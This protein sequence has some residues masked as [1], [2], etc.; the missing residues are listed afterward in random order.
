MKNLSKYSLII[1]TIV[2]LGFIFMLYTFSNIIH[3]AINSDVVNS[4][5]NLPKDI[6]EGDPLKYINDDYTMNEKFSSNLP[7]IIIEL[8]SELPYYKE[9]DHVN[10]GVIYNDIEPWTT[11]HISIISNEK[12]INNIND[13]AKWQSS[14]NVKRRGQTTYFYE[15]PQ[16]TI[17]L[18]SDEAPQIDKEMNLF[19]MG[20]DNTWAII[21]SVVDKSLIRNYLAYSIASEIDENTL[22][23]KFCEV[24]VKDGESYTYQGV[25]LFSEKVSR[26]K[27]RVNIENYNGVDK[28]SSYI[29]RRDRYTP[30]DVIIDNY[31]RTDLG[32]DTYLGIKYPSED[33]LNEVVLDYITEDFNKIEKTLYSEDLTTKKAYPEYIDI[34]SFV[35]YF[36]I[37][38][39]FGNYDAGLH[40]TYMYKNYDNSLKI[41]PVWDFDQAMNNYYLVEQKTEYTAMQKKAFYE[42]LIKDERF[43][44]ELMER[45]I[46]LRGTSLNEEYIVEKIDEITEY[47][48]SAKQREWYRWYDPYFNQDYDA[49]SYKL[50]DFVKNGVLVSRYNDDY[51]QEILIIKTYLRKHGDSI[52]NNIKTM[53]KEAEFTT[54]IKGYNTLILLGV[55]ILFALPSIILS[56]KG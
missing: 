10:G 25:Y 37:N 32:Y 20:S 23:T 15:K 11:G 18:V 6:S 12:G 44:E 55:L 22:D 33:E 34:D 19:N 16:Y 27:N 2:F 21:G 9:H 52:A 30:Y 4:Y 50:K 17:R 35:D 47:I 7:L 46:E 45:Y 49:S 24:A 38:E 26:S 48:D 13:E 51:E 31:L 8:D 41:G 40:S 56:K 14:I 1:I 36:L 29:L 3:D 28:Y 39:Y 54:D 43:L 53:K 5:E 42:E